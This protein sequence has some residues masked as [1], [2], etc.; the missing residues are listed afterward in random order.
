MS[1]SQEIPRK[2]PYPI[3]PHPFF[4]ITE[5]KIKKIISGKREASYHVVKFYNRVVS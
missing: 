1:P 2:P 5:R 4:H 3:P